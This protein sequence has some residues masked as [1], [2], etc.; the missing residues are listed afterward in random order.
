MAKVEQGTCGECQHFIPFYPIKEDPN[1]I[2][3]NCRRTKISAV[4]KTFSISSPKTAIL[5]SEL[6]ES[7]STLAN[8]GDEGTCF[9]PKVTRLPRRIPDLIEA[10]INHKKVWKKF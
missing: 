5:L 6:E 4:V 9:E 8:F 2:F 10:Y 1:I 3:G 7:V